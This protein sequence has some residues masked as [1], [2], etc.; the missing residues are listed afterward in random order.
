M[1]RHLGPIKAV[2][3]PDGSAAGIVDPAR[4]AL[5]RPIARAQSTRAR[6]A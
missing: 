4:R 3:E 5:R 2:A 1:A 6:A